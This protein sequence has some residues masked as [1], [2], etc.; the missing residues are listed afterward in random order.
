VIAQIWHET[1]SPARRLN[2]IFR[3]G[4]VAGT[5][6]VGCA[7]LIYGRSPAIILQ[8]IASGLIGVASFRG[9]AW[10][11]IL[12]LLLQWGMSILIAAIYSGVMATVP[13]MR[14]RWV[15]TG[16]VA[17]A[18]IF[19]VMNYI[20]APLSAAPFR[21]AFTVAGLLSAFTPI[22][23]VGNLLAMILFG[24]I[25]SFFARETSQAPKP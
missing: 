6:D 16:V 20:V 9:G 1:I 11:V 10:T 2:A 3:G 4:L 24:L 22:H 5:V 21:P 19:L 15:L 18:V 8:S 14:R 12:G 17:G 23:F 7:C 13:H 25:L